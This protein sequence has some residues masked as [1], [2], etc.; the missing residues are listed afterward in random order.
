MSTIKI[1]TRREGENTLIRILIQHPMETGR[2]R[3]EV[4]GTIIPAHFIT[5]LMVLHNHVT[6]IEGKLSTA[7]S[8]N[9]YFSFEIRNA[10]VG[11]LIEVIWRD[12]LGTQDKEETIINHDES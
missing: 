9:P 4:T 3:D 6:V 5:D 1:R 7:V 10:K 12:N 8:K 11:D 2:R